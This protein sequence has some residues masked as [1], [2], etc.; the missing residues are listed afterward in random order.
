MQKIVKKRKM[1]HVSVSLAEPLF[2]TMLLYSTET[3]LRFSAF[4]AS[5]DSFFC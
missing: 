1:Q 3:I 2:R 5:K 4:P